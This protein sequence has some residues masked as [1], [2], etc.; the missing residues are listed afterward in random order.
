MSRLS[1]YLLILALIVFILAC[2]FVT[3]PIRDAQDVVETAQSL[4][5]ALPVE[6]IRALASQIPVQTLEALPSVIPDFGNY[7]N[8]EGTPV[9][10][11]N[12]V[13]IMPQATAGQEFDKSVYSFKANATLKEAQDFYDAR[14]SD[15]GWNQPFSM[16]S[17]GDGA[18]MVFQRDSSVL[19][20]TIASVENSIVVILTLA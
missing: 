3:Q 2:N 11:W 4:A 12:D 6:T 18:I 14:L 9:E 13:P 8:P 16:P 5:T 15:L 1:K 10:V 19:T 17:E 7:F 20:I